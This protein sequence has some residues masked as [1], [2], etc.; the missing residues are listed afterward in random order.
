MREDLREQVVQLGV[1]VTMANAVQ[2][3]VVHHHGEIRVL[4][5]GVRAQDYCVRLDAAVPK[6]APEA[7][8]QDQNHYL[9]HAQC[10]PRDFEASASLR[11][12][13]CEV[14]DGINHR[15]A[16]GVMSECGI[17]RSNLSLRDQLRTEHDLCALWVW[18][19]SC[20][21]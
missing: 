8:T 12:F 17:V 19:A 16:E 10:T 11:Q 14:Q 15:V 1:H 2:D 5:R 21:W 9:H 13:P 20:A 3:L 18:V 4:T 6:C 7:N